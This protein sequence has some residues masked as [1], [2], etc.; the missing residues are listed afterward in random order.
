MYIQ[1]T[2]VSEQDFL[3]QTRILAADISFTKKSGSKEVFQ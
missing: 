1:A 3:E 2:R